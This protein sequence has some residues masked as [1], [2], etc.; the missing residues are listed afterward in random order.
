MVSTKAQL[1]PPPSQLPARTK[2]QLSA[3]DADTN[4]KPLH[5]A[6]SPLTPIKTL[7]ESPFWS[8]K[9]RPTLF[10][11]ALARFHIVCVVLAKMHR[12]LCF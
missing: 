3:S 5:P 4:D 12:R 8:N 7:V 1:M 11:V 2:K 6:A 10:K 9:V